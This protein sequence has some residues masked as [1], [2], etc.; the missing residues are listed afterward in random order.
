[1]KNYLVIG[2]SV[3]VILLPSP[4][5]CQS[6][7]TVEKRGDGFS[8]TL[9]ILS[10]EH[11]AYYSLGQEIARTEDAPLIRS[12]AELS[13]ISSRYVL[14]VASPGKI[15]AQTLL[16]FSRFFKASGNYPALGIITGS[17]KNTV[18]LSVFAHSG[19]RTPPRSE[20]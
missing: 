5:G 15:S 13:D 7:V 4:G 10:D 6:N 11:D 8:T 14:Y 9:V 16:T 19:H 17:S 3:I 2:L 18:F 1:M 20:G 12:I